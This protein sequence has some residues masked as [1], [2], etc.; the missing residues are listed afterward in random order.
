MNRWSPTASYLSLSVAAYAAC[1]VLAWLAPNRVE[2][3]LPLVVIGL[4]GLLF[5]GALYHLGDALRETGDEATSAGSSRFWGTVVAALGLNLGVAL[6]G[7]LFGLP[8]LFVAAPF[9]AIAVSTLLH[10]AGTRHAAMLAAMGVYIVCTLLANFTFDTFIE[11]PLYGMLSVGTL[12]FGITFTQ[13]DRVHRYGRRNVYL[14]IF[15][16]A[17]GNLALSLYLGIPL[18]FLAA[19]FL[20]IILAE[21]ADTEVYQRLLKRNW[22]VRVSTS[23]AVSIPLDSIIF[24]VIAFAGTFSVATMSEIVFADIIAKTVVGLLA[25][26]RLVR[27]HAVAPVPS[28]SKA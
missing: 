8:A 6:L 28:V 14:M 17:L 26:L 5:I 4:V 3:G 18:R 1:A 24:T 16:A 25:A 2:S 23:N 11:L 19:G 9:V 13:R 20:A 22:W 27:H 15:A 21:A 12:F 10:A 7:A